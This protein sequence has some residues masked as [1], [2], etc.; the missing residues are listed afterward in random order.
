M[1]GAAVVTGAC[2]LP[3]AA[4]PGSLR[5]RFSCC[6]PWRGSAN[7]VAQPAINL[8]MAEQVP[9]ERQGLAFGIKQSAIPGAILVSGLAL[10]LIAL[11]LGWRSAFA[12]AGV[13]GAG[14]RAGRRPGAAHARAG[15]DRAS[16]R[17]ARRARCC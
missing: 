3:I 2:L 12:L 17:G 13:G 1:R 11:P 10:P 6:C 15:A 16:L 14:G 4:L 9:L 8:F 7:S 5:G